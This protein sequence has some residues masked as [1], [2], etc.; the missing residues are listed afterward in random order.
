[1]IPIAVTVTAQSVSFKFNHKNAISIIYNLD[2]DNILSSP[3]ALS[4]SVITIE[5]SNAGESY[6]IKI[7]EDENQ[8]V[9]VDNLQ[10]INYTN[11][12]SI[13]R[14]MTFTNDN[15][16]FFCFCQ[17]PFFA[18]DNEFFDNVFF[19]LNITENE[20][21]YIIYSS[22]KSFFE[23]N[24]AYKLLKKIVKK[25]ANISDIEPKHTI[26]GL[27]YEIEAVPISE[28][29]NKL[30]REIRGTVESGIRFRH[31]YEGTEEP[32]S[33]IDLIYHPLGISSIDWKDIKSKYTFFRTIVD[34]GIGFEGVYNHRFASGYSP[35]TQFT[36]Y[37]R[38]Q[39]LP[40]INIGKIETKWSTY[41]ASVTISHGYPSLSYKFSCNNSDI[42]FDDGKYKKEIAKA[43]KK[44]Y[45]NFLD[46]LRCNGFKIKK[47]EYNGNGM[48]FSKDEISGSIQL[49][50]NKYTPQWSELEI[51]LYH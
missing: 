1:M 10:N 6:S 42:P 47:S 33:L 24:S 25:E 8:V 14:T 13:G 15:Q 32:L 3:T 18:K 4:K 16:H 44:S 36:M 48:D 46:E 38:T 34:F 35:A 11:T 51:Q 21:D 41:E 30:Y 5:T 31:S 20:A 45:D 50:F 49:N 2:K 37:K 23:Y 26:A 22:P 12:D 39:L 27:P 29:N 7:K 9:I 43:V 17:G 19:K 40:T 28:L